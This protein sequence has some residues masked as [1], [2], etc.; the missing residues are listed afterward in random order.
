MRIDVT[1][2]SESETVFVAKA[3]AAMC[4]CELHDL[5]PKRPVNLNLPSKP[6]MDVKCGGLIAPRKM[7]LWRHMHAS[8][9]FNPL[10]PDRYDLDRDDFDDKEEVDRD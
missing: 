1:Q 9:G 5:Q 6:Y 8:V 2:I 10:D 4:L 7:E 3:N